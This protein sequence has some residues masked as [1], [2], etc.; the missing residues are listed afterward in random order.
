MIQQHIIYM[1]CRGKMFESVIKVYDIAAG[2][3]CEDAISER[4]Y[5]SIKISK[6][7]IPRK[8]NRFFI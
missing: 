4:K 5:F 7:H 1:H 6:D 3:V 8:S 2:N